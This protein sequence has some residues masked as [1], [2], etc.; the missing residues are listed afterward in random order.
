MRRLLMVVSLLLVAFVA[1]D[2]AEAK[3]SRG[4]QSK[5]RKFLAE[6]LSRTLSPEKRDAAAAAIADFFDDKRKAKELKEV[7]Q[8]ADLLSN[9]A[10]RQG[11]RCGSFRR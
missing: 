4:E 3:L 10:V 7:E 6:Y 9:C 1:A 8:L 5:M 11:Q 2:H